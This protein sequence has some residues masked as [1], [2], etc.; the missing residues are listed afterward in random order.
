M[1]N[2]LCGWFRHGQNNAPGFGS[3]ILWMKPTLFSGTLADNLRFGHPAASEELVQNAAAIAQIDQFAQ[4]LADGYNTLIG[5]GGQGLS[6]G[7]MQRVSIARAL[8]P[9]PPI[10]ILDEATSALDTRT[11]RMVAKAL[12]AAAAGRTTLVIAHRLTTITN[13]DRIVVMGTNDKGFG[14]IKAVG[15]HQELLETSSGLCSALRKTG[16]AQSDPHAHRPQLQHHSGSADG[17]GVIAFVQQ[18]AGLCAGFW[19]HLGDGQNRGGAVWH[20]DEQSG[21]DLDRSGQCV[22]Q[23][24]GTAADGFV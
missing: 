24:A 3:P 19:G 23:T 22:P 6:G 21:N 4:S 5:S 9:D 12:D 18:R 11:E 1:K 15:T 8:V 14:L 20:S 17:G 13:A 10:L 7:Q 16:P 2:S